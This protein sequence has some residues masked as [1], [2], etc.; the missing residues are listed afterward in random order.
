[1]AFDGKDSR[2]RSRT[3]RDDKISDPQDAFVTIR[4]PL[5]ALSPRLLAGLS[6]ALV[7]LIG[8]YVF[9]GSSTKQ[10]SATGPS[11]PTRSLAPS[12]TTRS[13]T[14]NACQ[15]IRVHS[16]PTRPIVFASNR[17]GFWQIWRM[18]RDGSHQQQVTPG[19]AKGEASQ[20]SLSPDGKS[21]V[22]T[23]IYYS[24]TP[25]QS[26]IH[27]FT[28]NL[29][30]TNRREISN[31]NEDRQADWSPDGRHIVFSSIRDAMFEIYT[32]NA[33]GSHVRRLTN[34]Q[35]WNDGYGAYGEGDFNP[36]WS[37]DGNWITFGRNVGPRRGI[38]VMRPDGSGQHV[39]K[40]LATIAET[41]SWSPDGCHIAFT[42]NRGLSYDIYIMRRDG[43]HLHRITSRLVADQAAW[44]PDATEIIFRGSKDTNS[45]A[46]IYRIRISGGTPVNLTGTRA[47][48]GMPSWG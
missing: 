42:L 40:K 45:Q 20:P 34:T 15:H 38:W 30:G 37:P 17:S 18:N 3:K 36:S 39:I 26:H 24:G 12:P 4:N 21:I 46:E 44:S 33:D 25:P 41:P 27:L 16:D 5:K 19:P 6:L 13:V 29:D 23:N 32:S 10:T 9:L 2:T 48:E 7:G 8:S 43:S 1:M 28:Q 35:P 22:Y 11:G 14:P 47:D 31:G